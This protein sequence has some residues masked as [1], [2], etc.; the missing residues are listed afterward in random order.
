MF[1]QAVNAA[2]VR[3]AAGGLLL[4]Q[5]PGATFAIGL[6]K[7]RS[8][9]A[10]ACFRVRRASD[11]TEQ[12]IGFTGDLLNTTALATFCSG[13]TGFIRK[14]YDQSV[15]ENEAGNASTALQPRIF[16]AGAIEP[17]GALFSSDL[18]TITNP[19]D[20]AITGSTPRTLFGVFRRN[21]NQQRWLMTVR[22]L[23]TTGNVWAFTQE[24]AI[25]IQAG[26]EVYTT[27]IPNSLELVTLTLTG[28][29]VTNHNLRVD[30]V[31]VAA[32]SSSARTLNTQITSA[33]I[34][35]DSIVIPSSPYNGYISELIVYNSDQTSNHTG[36]ETNINN[37]YHAY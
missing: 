9:Y 5:Y 15:N 19:T 18:L 3:P 27:A 10:G 33:E 17:N 28:T 26:N 2:R 4:D 16:N 36:I 25:R 20:L 24:Y 21:D 31:A 8:T 23:W 12:D 6:R 32:V 30:A 1:F 35:A 13:T 14:W 29:D 34:G 22:N 37:H 7:L 11:N